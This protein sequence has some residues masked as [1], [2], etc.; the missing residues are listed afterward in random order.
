VAD[1]VGLVGLVTVNAEPVLLR[2]DRDGAQLE[3]GAGAKDAHGDLAAIGRHQLFE[4][5][6]RRWV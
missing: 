6:K 1:L 4:R 5:T 3:F 2:V